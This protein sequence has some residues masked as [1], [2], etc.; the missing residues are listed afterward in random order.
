MPVHGTRGHQRVLGALIV[1]RVQK[2]LSSEA[3]CQYQ[4][5]IRW[6]KTQLGD[7]GGRSDL[8]KPKLAIVR[9]V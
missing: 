4:T 1:H 2:D 8:G 6:V 7:T 5:R 9:L 3:S